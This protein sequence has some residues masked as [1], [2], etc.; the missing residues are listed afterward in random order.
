MSVTLGARTNAA[1]NAGAASTTVSVNSTSAPLVVRVRY[2]RGS[3]VRDVS[4]VTFNSVALTRI[5]NSPNSSADD[6]AEVWI[7]TTPSVGTFN[8]VVTFTGTGM[9]GEIDSHNAAGCDTTTP[10]GNT[11]TGVS[12]TLQ[13]NTGD[14]AI[15]G[16][17][18]DLILIDLAN[19]DGVSTAGNQAASTVGGGTPTETSDANA[20]GEGVFG[21]HVDASGVTTARVDYGSFAAAAFTFVVLLQST[22]PVPPP[23]TYRRFDPG[24]M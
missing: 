13:N 14:V 7:L 15:T 10:A 8:V 22:G 11:A 3:P 6:H 1:I 21:A 19:S 12:T 5:V 23:Y 20:G 17:A 16:S 24:P 4:G 2:W 9:V 18:G